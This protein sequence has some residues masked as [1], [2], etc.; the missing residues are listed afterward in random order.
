[1]S[2]VSSAGQMI[3]IEINFKHYT[4]GFKLFNK[5][6]KRV[7]VSSSVGTFNALKNQEVCIALS[8]RHKWKFTVISNDQ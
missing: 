1:M 5:G 8:V 6:N 4:V 7:A 3:E 2:P